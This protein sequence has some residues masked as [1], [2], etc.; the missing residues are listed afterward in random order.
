MPTSRP[1]VSSHAAALVN[2][3]KPLVIQSLAG[4]AA[5]IDSKPWV[6]LNSEQ[7]TK[8]AAAIRSVAQPVL[9]DIQIFIRRYA[10]DAAEYKVHFSPLPCVS[11]A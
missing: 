5:A 2:N 4:K 6:P 9:S 7:R 11:D 8:L 3:A 1:P 10:R